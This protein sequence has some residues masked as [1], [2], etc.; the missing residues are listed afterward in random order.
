VPLQSRPG[1]AGAGTSSRADRLM[2]EGSR[3]RSA[4]QVYPLAAPVTQLVYATMQREP[5]FV[6]RSAVRGR[7]STT[8]QNL[9][10]QRDAAN[11]R[12]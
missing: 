9:D 8:D 2:N 10:T 1:R 7:V 5:P 6:L 11:R 3:T 4:G 12:V